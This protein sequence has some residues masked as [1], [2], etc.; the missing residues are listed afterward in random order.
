MTSV[1]KSPGVRP[2]SERERAILRRLLSVDFDGVD[3]VRAQ[4]SVVRHVEP[5]CTCGCP[6]VTPHVDRSA[7]PAARR[8]SLFPAE[9]VEVRRADGI[10]RT[11][12]CFMDQDGYIANLECAYYDDALPE[13]PDPQD[14]VVLVHDEQQHLVAVALPDDAVVRPRRTDARWSSFAMQPD[15]GWCAQTTSGDRE[16]FTAD[17]T[18]VDPD[19]DTED[20]RSGLEGG[21]FGPRL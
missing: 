15:G 5:N 2:V 11:V 14:C 6:S 16:Y 7:A 21:T 9:L 4:A 12:L 1:A 18:F 17:G 8:W 13:W 10:P 19:L 20:R 3:A